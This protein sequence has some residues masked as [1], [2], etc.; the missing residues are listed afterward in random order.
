MP[1]EVGTLAG[2]TLP[3]PD[4]GD[5][6]ICLSATDTLGC[7]NSTCVDVVITDMLTIY[8]P[9]AFTPDGDGINSFFLPSVIGMDADSYSFKVFDRWGLEV[10][11][12]ED[13]GAG[14]NGSL[15]NGGAVL[16]QDV[17]V[18]RLWVKEAFTTERKE[19]FGTVTLLK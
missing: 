7:V 1:W 15:D 8:A 11:S 10:F 13:P 19:V 2:L 3:Y 4:V 5:H 17:Y 6:V 18:W 12:S 14:W 9:N 16:P